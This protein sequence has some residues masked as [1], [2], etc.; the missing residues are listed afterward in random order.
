[1]KSECKKSGEKSRQMA[2]VSTICDEYCS[3]IRFYVCK[4][5]FHDLGFY[6]FS[7]SRSGRLLDTTIKQHKPLEDSCLLN[8]A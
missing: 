7:F 4:N 8:Y 2:P 5:S 6:R 1:M 3:L